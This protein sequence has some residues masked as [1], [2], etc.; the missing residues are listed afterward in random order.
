[1]GD[2]MLMLRAFQCSGE[3]VHGVVYFTGRN[4]LGHGQSALYLP[5]WPNVG[6]ADGLLL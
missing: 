6:N 4:F 1:M 2:K 5:E 3:Y